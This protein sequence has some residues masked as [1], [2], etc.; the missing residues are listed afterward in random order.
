[1]S[2]A[3]RPRAAQ[4]VAAGARSGAPL[5][6]AAQRA[7]DGVLEAQPLGS[8]LRVVAGE[9]E[10]VEPAVLGDGTQGARRDAQ[11]DLAAQDLA[12]ERRLLQVRVEAALGLAVRVGDVVTGLGVGARELAAARHGPGARYFFGFLAPPKRRRKRSILPSASSS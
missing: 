5:G 2:P 12:G 9:Q 11:G 7:P 4:C 8:E 10:G 6:A 3:S 1:R